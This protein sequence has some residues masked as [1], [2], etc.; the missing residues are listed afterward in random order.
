MFDDLGPGDALLYGF[1]QEENGYVWSTFAFGMVFSRKAQRAVLAAHYPHE[2]G[3]LR[4]H[5]KQAGSRVYRLRKGINKLLVSY[6][7]GDTLCHFEVS[8]R[9]ALPSDVRELGLMV[10]AVLTEPS[11]GPPPL[12][13]AEA[14]VGSPDAWV[15]PARLPTSHVLARHLLESFIGRGCAMACIEGHADAPQ[16]ELALFLPPGERCGPELTAHISVNGTLF[17]VPVRQSADA[18]GYS[19]AHLPAIAYRAFLSLGDFLDQGG[20]LVPLDIFIANADGSAKFADQEFFWRGKGIG[21]DPSPEQIYRVAGPASLDW[22]RLTG[23]TWYEK[24]LRLYSRLTGRSIEACGPILDWGVGC[25]RIARFFPEHL[26]GRVYGVDIDALNIDWCRKNIPGIQFEVTSPAPPLP[27]ADRHFELVY[28][29][30]VLTHLSENDQR[31]WLHELARVT[32]PGGHCLLTVLA[33]VSWFIRYYPDGRCPDSVAE[34][35]ETG[36]F[37][38]GTMDVG[39]DSATPGTYR[40]VSHTQPYIRRVWSEYFEV[41]SIIQNFA[42]LQSLVVL[43]RR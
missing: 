4:V 18:T 6:D 22:M 43:R 17:A 31:A 8:P 28:G 35:L 14:D 29:H 7:E 34:F 27:F 42:D 16:L 3:V 13:F 5:N 20:D 1:N 33:E 40:N 36:F 10:C 23:A 30:S 24:L 2:S 19:F 26:R 39:V 37:D 15:P 21:A 41:V 32:R 9:R 12:E 25:A 38:D 11:P